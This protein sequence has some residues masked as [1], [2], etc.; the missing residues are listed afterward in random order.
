[1]DKKKFI[2]NLTVLI[3]LFA[4]SFIAL[5]ISF[6]YNIVLIGFGRKF[7]LFTFWMISLG[8]YNRVIDFDNQ[9]TTTL[10]MINII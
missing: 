6:K 10:I 8:V 9:F 4:C 7:F 2:K 5:L 3:I 1:M